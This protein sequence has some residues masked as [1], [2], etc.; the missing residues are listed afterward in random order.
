M[1]QTREDIIDLRYQVAAVLRKAQCRAVNCE[2]IDT[3][4][5]IEGELVK[6]DISIS[7]LILSFITL[8]SVIPFNAK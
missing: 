4:A 1:I 6:L 5:N 8:M 2:I 7:C 3:L